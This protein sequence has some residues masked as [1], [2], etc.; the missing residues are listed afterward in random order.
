MYLSSTDLNS[1][2]LYGC[3]V[4]SEAPSFST[5]KSEDEMR[6]YGE[7]AV[8][9]KFVLKPSQ[10]FIHIDLAHSHYCTKISVESLCA[11]YW[12]NN[13]CFLFIILQNQN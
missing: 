7:L 2:G 6:I 10:I 9:V 1:E 8:H 13:K 4:S 3:E 11:F 5:A 12:N